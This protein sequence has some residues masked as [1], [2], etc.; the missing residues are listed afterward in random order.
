[1]GTPNP[2]LH[3]APVS[4]RKRSPQ[5]LRRKKPGKSSLQRHT[6]WFHQS[7]VRNKPM[8]LDIVTG[9]D[10][11]ILREASRPVEKFD[12][13]LHKLIKDMQETMLAAKG[14]GLAAVQIGNPIRLAIIRINH[15]TDRET[16]FPV[17]NPKITEFS[18]E[19][20]VAEEGCLSLPNI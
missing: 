10:N 17:I 13:S 4:T 5:Q 14:I 12:K 11:P 20:T 6:R 1:M 7:H 2:H 3:V 16:I 9:S 19:K 8:I 18:K 15:G